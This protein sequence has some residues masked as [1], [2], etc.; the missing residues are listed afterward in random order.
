MRWKV[1]NG[2]RG[3]PLGEVIPGK[4]YRTP[5]CQFCHMYQAEG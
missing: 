3:K 5:T 2:T 1:K 4:D